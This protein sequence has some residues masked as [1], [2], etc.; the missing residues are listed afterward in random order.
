MSALVLG[1]VRGVQPAQDAGHDAHDDPRR[2][3]LVVS[4]EAA[5]DLGERLALD[6]FHD[7]EQLTPRRDDV[8]RGDDVRVTDPRGEARLVEKHR[9]ELGIP[10]VDGVQ[11]LDRHGAAEA[12]GPEEPPDVDGRHPAGSD[13]GIERVAP[14]PPRFYARPHLLIVS[15]VDRRSRECGWSVRDRRFPEPCEPLPKRGRGTYARI[16]ISGAILKNALRSGSL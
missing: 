9:D 6:V 8:D 7:D 15:R 10:R 16:G 14:N 13:L 1:L 3:P 11:A 4:A 2:H 12:D 5:S